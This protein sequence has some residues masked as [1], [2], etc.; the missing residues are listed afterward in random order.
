M[1]EKKSRILI[2]IFVALLVVPTV[3]GIFVHSGSSEGA[4]KRELA[5]MPSIG[6]TRYSEYT[7]ELAAYYN[8]HLPL[9]SSLVKLWSIANY[10]LFGQTAGEQVIA[11]KDGWLFYNPQNEGS[12]DTIRG[13]MGTDQLTED[14]LIRIENGLLNIK[15]WC[16]EAGSRMIVM[17]VPDKERIYS[18]YMPACYGTP[19]EVSR[20]QQVVDAMADT[21]VDVMYLL[22]DFMS[23]KDEASEL[24]YYKHDSHWTGAAAYIGARAM[25]MHLGY[26]MPKLSELTVCEIPPMENDLAVL[27]GLG[28]YLPEDVD[29]KVGSVSEFADILPGDAGDLWAAWRTESDN[30]SGKKIM[31]VRDSFGMEIWPYI[32]SEYSK[33]LGVYRYDSDWTYYPRE[34]IKNEAPD[35]FVMEVSESLIRDLI[36]YDEK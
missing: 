17:I 16:D 34:Y 9:R 8:D 22:D 10:S 11:G 2:V 3:L 21:D 36:G 35:V 32:H 1:R 25:Q 27:A 4:E 12:R 33:T 7:A 31:M 14:E 26:E 30:T 28:T 23:A 5:K 6:E 20:G 18:E 24:L 19:C 15:S 13:Y 29:Y